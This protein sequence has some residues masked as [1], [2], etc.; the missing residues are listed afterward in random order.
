[1]IKTRVLWWI[2]MDIKCDKILFTMTTNWNILNQIYL[3]VVGVLSAVI[4]ERHGSPR[5]FLEA[6]WITLRPFYINH[7]AVS[8]A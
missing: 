6:S 3:I 2:Q 8:C 5:W 1:M 4:A 7:G